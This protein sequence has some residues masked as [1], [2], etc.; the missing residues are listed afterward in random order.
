MVLSPPPLWRR[1]CEL[2]PPPCVRDRDG[3]SQRRLDQAGLVSR[4]MS[5]LLG[6]L[7]TRRAAGL[8]HIRHSDSVPALLSRLAS[9]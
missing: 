8:V 1:C 2:W 6:R 5:V 4:L 7:G 9:L 3:L